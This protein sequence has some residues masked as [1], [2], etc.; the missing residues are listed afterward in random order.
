M[1]WQMRFLNCKIESVKLVNRTGWWFEK[2][3]KSR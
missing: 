3:D 2:I 1:K